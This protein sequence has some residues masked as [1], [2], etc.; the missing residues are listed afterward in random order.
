MTDQELNQIENYIAYSVVNI[1]CCCLY[2][3]LAAFYYTTDRYITKISGD[4][5]GA[6][7]VSTNARK[8]NIVVTILQLII[9]FIILI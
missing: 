4:I 5:Q 6:L 9:C 7:N 3:D 1:F 2:V 8:L